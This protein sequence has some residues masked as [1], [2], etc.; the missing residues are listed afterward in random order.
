MGIATKLVSGLVSSV[1]LVSLSLAMQQAYLRH[2]DSVIAESQPERDRP[3][4]SGTSARTLSSRGSS[5]FGAEESWTGADPDDHPAHPSRRGGLARSENPGDPGARSAATRRASQWWFW[6]DPAPAADEGRVTPAPTGSSGGATAL[7]SRP[8][9][10][11]ASSAPTANVAQVREVFF[12]TREDTACQPGV[13]R[14]VLDDVRDLYVCVVWAG[15][16][17]KYAE[18]LT[19]VSPDGHVYQTLT[20][21]F[22][23][24]DTTTA[25]SMIEIEGRRLQVKAAGWGANGEALVTAALPVAGTFITQ[26]TLVGLWKV[27]VGLNGRPLNEDT[28]ELLPR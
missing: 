22:A 19:F 15:V 16:A 27:E 18:Q 7:T 10:E 21:P 8:S 26:R 20:V 6:R 5:G 12:S 23:T 11:P 2:L 4:L 28:F 17:G 3:G 14:F 9:G 25:G 24:A 13:R 1:L